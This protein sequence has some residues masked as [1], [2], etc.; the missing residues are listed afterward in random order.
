MKQEM[1]LTG[2][3]S[4]NEATRLYPITL[5]VFTRFGIDACCGG[6]L[7]ISVAAERHGTD[8]DTLLE[9]LRSA[10][11]EDPPER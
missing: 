5:E 2:Q 7:P 8:V 11:V 9:Q 1:G 4:V 3:M 10:A 6:A